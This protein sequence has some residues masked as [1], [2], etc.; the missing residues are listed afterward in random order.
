MNALKLL[1][2]APERM[3]YR[4]SNRS[5]DALGSEYA[6]GRVFVWSAFSSTATTIDVMNKFLGKEGRTIF[7]LEMN[8]ST[9][10]KELKAFSL[11]AS[12]NEV[13]L[14]P[15]VEFKMISKYVVGNGLTIIQC[16]Q[17]R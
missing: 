8:G 10:G 12:E 3:L 14:E 13:L 11:Y 15:N 4:A 7:H 17:M 9:V 5:A 1:P 2:D 16:K 6:V